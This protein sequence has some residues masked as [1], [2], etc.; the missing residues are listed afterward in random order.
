MLCVR[1]AE[2]SATE[3]QYRAVTSSECLQRGQPGTRR[4]EYCTRLEAQAN[5]FYPPNAVALLSSL[6]S[7][8]PIAKHANEVVNAM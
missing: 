1:T 7:L 3:W 6:R 4:T 5:R 2:R 8:T